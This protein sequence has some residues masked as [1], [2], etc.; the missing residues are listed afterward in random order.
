MPMKQQMRATQKDRAV[1][2]RMKSRPTRCANLQCVDSSR[3]NFLRAFF[4]L[5]IWTGRGAC[6]RAQMRRAS[7]PQAPSC[8][9]RVRAPGAIAARRPGPKARAKRAARRHGHA[10]RRAHCGIRARKNARIFDTARVARITFSRLCFKHPNAPQAPSTD[11]NC[12][13]FCC[14]CAACWRRY[15][16]L[17][18]SAKIISSA[19]ADDDLKRWDFSTIRCTFLH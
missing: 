9:P 3:E 8:A 5:R 13:S 10:L 17:G 12:R 15:F 6:Q 14:P 18:G 2:G 16:P 1:F 4:A 11:K 7:A 19:A